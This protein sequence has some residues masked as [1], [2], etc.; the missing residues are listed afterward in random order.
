MIKT[1]AFIGLGVMG[2]PM[3]CNLVKAGFAVY[4]YNRSRAKLDQLAASGGNAAG[5]VAEAVRDADMVITTLPDWPAVRQVML[6]PEGVAENAR[7]GTLVV[8]M[9]SVSPIAARELRAALTEKRLRMLDAPISGGEPRAID[10]TL[11]I[12]AGGGKADFDEALPVFKALGATIN[13]IGDIGAGSVCKV[14]NQLL[15]M[16]NIASVS[17]TLTFAAKAGVDSEMVFQTIRTGLGGSNILDAKDP[18]M[19][20]GDIKPGGVIKYHAKDLQNAFD[21]AM[22]THMP[23]PIHAVAREIIQ[24]C[25]ADGLGDADHG[26]MIR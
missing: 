13:R 24:S 11:T 1:I 20:A 14:C 16:A 22:E 15:V 9:T 12:M 5:S 4:G 17:E 23:M 3:A 26:C 7:P 25:L 10:G 6:G 19:L 8:D 18:M 2:L 21:I